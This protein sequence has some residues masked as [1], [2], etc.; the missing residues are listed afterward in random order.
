MAFGNDNV[1]KLIKMHDENKYYDDLVDINLNT[2]NDS[3]AYLCRRISK[4][5]TVLDI[6]CAQGFIGNILKN[7]LNCKVY[8]IELDKEAIKIAKKS[9]NYEKLYNFDI[10]KRNNEDYKKFIEDNVKFD[11][12][13]FAD[14]L[15]H[16][17]DPA[18]AIIFCFDFLNKNGK[19]LTSLPN[20]AHYDIID[21]LLNDKFNYSEMGLL[22]NTHI[23][24][25]TKYSFA[26][27]IKSIGDKLN[28]KID[29]IC[30]NSTVIKPSFYKDYKALNRIMKKH[31][32]YL[33]LQN[34]FEI[35]PN[36]NNT[37]NL[38]NILNEK[39]EN[40]TKIINEELNDL[41]YLRDKYND[42]T[43]KYSILKNEYARINY[44][45]NDKIL[46]N[47]K[48]RYS[49]KNPIR[50]FDE[51]FKYKKNNN[52]QSILFFVHA[53]RNLNKVHST[54]IGGTTLYLIELINSLKS[55]KNC[56]VVTI[57]NNKYMLVVIEKNKEYIYDLGI[58]VKYNNF[59]GYDFDFYKVIKSLIYNLQID[60]LHINHFINFPCDLAL[61]S[62]EIKTLVTIHDYT[63]IC[64]R[65]F[66][67]DINDNICHN[68]SYDKCKNCIEGYTQSNYNLRNESMK[69]LFENASNVIIPDE[70]ILKKLSIIYD[71]K[72]VSVIP[73]GLNVS[74][75]NEFDYN[76]KPINKDHINIAFVGNIEGHKGGKIIRDLIEKSPK[77]I[78]YHFLGMAM[79][80]FYL[81]N[82]KNYKYHGIYQKKN[83]PKLLNN[84]NINLV[85][86]LN[87]CEE[88]Y[89]Y[90]LSEV[91]Y[92]KIPIVSFD[93]GA[94]GNR[95][96]KGNLGIVVDK[97]DDY[98]IILSAIENIINDYSKYKLNVDK[99]QLNNVEEYAKIIKELYNIKDKE[100]IK[101]N[102]RKQYQYL[103]SYSLY[104]INHL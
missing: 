98:N 100:I 66:L 84:N 21:G 78:Y 26:E 97:T 37:N 1:N 102:I 23:R 60:L 32:E 39:R 68:Y 58:T 88:S 89:S 55:Q 36:S 7:E 74:I 63:F 79:D 41:N 81:T 103:H 45:L 92:S 104:K 16:L 14:V 25:F 75:F 33:V 19:I 91:I 40:I 61:L 48:F 77:K 65:Y 54:A 90:T 46:L 85:L 4:G 8:G 56:Y 72:N 24:F 73:H 62:S 101:K 11:Y 96:K 57:I 6:G 31:N 64:P 50:L 20:I 10:L 51:I 18:E 22:D 13:I 83:L 76:N 2:R 42:L 44:E 28:K 5:S 80:E 3:H 30:F 12:I 52:N 29:L 35:I 99:Y 93:I 67:L 15:E 94:I 87:Q 86:F 69:R 47:R 27:Y 17:Y 71:C 43:N 53:W 38:D 49:S 70:S 82:S 9:N 95:V 59:D 34:M